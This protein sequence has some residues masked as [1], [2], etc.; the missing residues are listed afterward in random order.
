MTGRAT[1]PDGVAQTNVVNVGSISDPKLTE[2]KY[3][4]APSNRGPKG[5]LFSGQI[6]GHGFLFFPGIEPMENWVAVVVGQYVKLP[7][8]HGFGSQ[9]GRFTIFGEWATPFVLN[10]RHKQLIFEGYDLLLL[11]WTQSCL[12]FQVPEVSIDGLLFLG[13]MAR[14]CHHVHANYLSG[15]GVGNGQGARFDVKNRVWRHHVGH[16]GNW[17]GPAK[18]RNGRIF[19]L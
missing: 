16:V 3:I 18:N 17:A 19:T 14:I 4:V 13:I 7:T 12:A 5:F 1:A 2:H 9:S 8:L 15:F 11:F 6:G 10:L